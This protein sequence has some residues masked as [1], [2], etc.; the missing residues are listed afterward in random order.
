MKKSYKYLMIISALL[1][2][3]A[4]CSYTKEISEKFFPNG[5]FN[6]QVVKGDSAMEIGNFGKAIAAYEEAA[7]LKP[8]DWDLKLKQA[9]G[10]ELDGKL[11]QAFNIYQ[12][13]IDS[14]NGV[15][16]S[17]KVI[18]IAK[19]NQAKLGF[20]KE[21]AAPDAKPASTITLD[22]KAAVAETIAEAKRPLEIPANA[23]KPADVAAAPTP[24]PAPKAPVAVAQEKAVAPEV[25]KPASNPEDTAI[26]AAVE[27]WRSAW[28]D[29]NLD[30][31]V[32]HYAQDFKGEAKTRKAWLAQR[33]SKI[34]HG[35]SIKLELSN[36][37]VKNVAKDTFDVEFTQ[38][39]Q[40]ASYNDKGTKT[41]RLKREKNRWVIVQESFKH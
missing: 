6:T 27:G 26:L 4:S 15:D 20:G 1:V 33:K 37:N 31:Y 28:I 10:Y 16:S 14:A 13:I 3:L 41:L 40:S 9:K 5:D 36:F 17:E 25:A 34:S 11:A 12:V 21:P 22:S 38:N 29:Q 19:T 24:A 23:Y 8:N 2:V 35:K 7:K 18:A 39:Y 32:D 30:A